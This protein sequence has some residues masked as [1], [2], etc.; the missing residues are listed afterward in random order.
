VGMTE[1]RFLATCKANYT[2]AVKR[3]PRFG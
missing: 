1:E 3:A 2:E